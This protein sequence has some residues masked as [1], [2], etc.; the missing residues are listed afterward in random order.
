[1][2][3]EVNPVNKDDD[4]TRTR[5]ESPLPGQD[6]HTPSDVNAVIPGIKLDEA[7]THLAEGKVKDAVFRL[8]SLA[9]IHIDKNQ[10]LSIDGK[11]FESIIWDEITKVRTVDY[12]PECETKLIKELTPLMHKRFVEHVRNLRADWEIFTVSRTFSTVRERYLAAYGRALTAMQE[13][14]ETSDLSVLSDKPGDDAIHGSG[15]YLK[16]KRVLR[17]NLLNDGL[18]LASGK[19]TVVHSVLREVCRVGMNRIRERE[20]AIAVLARWESDGYKNKDAVLAVLRKKLPEV[21]DAFDSGV[22]YLL[23]RLQK[24]LVSTL[25]EAVTDLDS[26]D[27]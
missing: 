22:S 6:P 14:V 11:G 2:E 16:Q 9:R 7:G 5:S 25:S 23:G 3:H 27:S 24:G 4:R 1:M 12:P 26:K 17:T 20:R 19:V 15:V 21:L 8:F 18:L 10:I 13:S